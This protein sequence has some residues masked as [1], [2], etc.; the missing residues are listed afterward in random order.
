[1]WWLCE[2]SLDVGGLH[3]RVPPRGA[4]EPALMVLVP[5][6]E[7]EDAEVLLSGAEGR[8]I[9]NIAAALRLDADAIYWAAALPRHTPAPHWD[10][11]RRAGLGAVLQHHITLV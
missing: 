7:A 9:T 10:E 6:P 8:L 1:T 11:L 4:A 5:M 3:P 2:P